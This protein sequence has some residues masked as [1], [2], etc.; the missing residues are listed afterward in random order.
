MLT[1]N[2]DELAKKYL[3]EELGIQADA[4]KDAGK[5]LIGFFEILYYIDQ[6]TNLEKQPT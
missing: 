6:R 3:I 5:N 2:A 1:E 4:A